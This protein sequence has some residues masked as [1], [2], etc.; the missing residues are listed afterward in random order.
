MTKT[1]HLQG[2]ALYGNQFAAIYDDIYRHKNYRG[3]CD[4]VARLSAKYAKDNVRRLVDLGCGTGSHS[5]DLASRGYD[6]TGIDVSP[7]MLTEA[8]KK[9]AVA[10]TAGKVWFIEGDIATIKPDGDFDA[11]LMLF[12]VLGYYIENQVLVKLLTHVRKMLRPGGLLIFD[13]WFG[14]AVITHDPG[15][16]VRRVPISEGEVLRFSSGNLDLQKQLCSIAFEFW[17]VVDDRILSR[18][19]EKHLIRY[20][21]PRE[22]EL[23][24]EA[25]GFELCDM[26]TLNAFERVPGSDD[27][28]V[29][30]VARA[31]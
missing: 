19:V 24:L 7:A 8:E 18:V 5:L 21:F 28:D 16:Q 9:L 27:R 2:P 10:K 3:E 15:Q 11:A 22:I 12:T 30:C 29:F 26:G 20:F 25:S 14:P 13:I 31:V 6:V 23:L 4:L 1:T 17:H